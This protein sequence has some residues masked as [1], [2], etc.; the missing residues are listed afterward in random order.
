VVQMPVRQHQDLSARFRAAFEQLI[1]PEQPAG[2]QV[3]R[4]AVPDPFDRSNHRL[5]I[6][7]L[8]QR[9][10]DL[11]GIVEHYECEKV[12]AAQISND[13]RA[14]FA[15]QSKRLAGHGTGPVKDN[16][17]GRGTQTDVLFQLRGAKTCHE[18]HRARFVT[19]NGLVVER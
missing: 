19:K 13:G 15:R 17:K 10:N 8:L 2:H 7:P 16:P 12:V 14:G 4:S 3:R 5:P 1:A 18:M 9:D 6:R 11:G